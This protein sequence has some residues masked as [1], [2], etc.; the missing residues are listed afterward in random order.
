MVKEER[1][2]LRDELCDFYI[3]VRFVELRCSLNKFEI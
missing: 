2:S 3:R 1:Q